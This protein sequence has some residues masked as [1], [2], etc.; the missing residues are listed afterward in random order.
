M[1]RIQDSEYNNEGV[2][3]ERA[4]LFFFSI[5]AQNTRVQVESTV[6]LFRYENL[7][8][9]WCSL[10]S[11]GQVVCTAHRRTEAEHG[12][13]LL[14]PERVLVEFLVHVRQEHAQRLVALLTGTMA[15]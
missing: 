4:L 10:S 9:G 8:T 15:E 1:W 11:Q 6:I 2:Q 3:V 14:R 7:K 5:K 13:S 12:E